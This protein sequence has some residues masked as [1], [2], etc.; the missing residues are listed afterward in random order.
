MHFKIDKIFNP[1][2]TT[3]PIGQG[4]GMGLAVSYSIITEK[5][6]GNIEVF[7]KVNEGTKVVIEMPRYLEKNNDNI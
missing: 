1:F 2:F 7:S 6:Q 3:K 4:T 5:H